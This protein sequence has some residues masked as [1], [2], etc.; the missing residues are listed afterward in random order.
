MSKT[1]EEKIENFCKTIGGYNNGRFMLQQLFP[2]REGLKEMRKIGGPDT[3]EEIIETM[4]TLEKS[5]GKWD[6]KWY[7]YPEK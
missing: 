2:I 4:E 1:I 7:E 6:K 5:E 3:L